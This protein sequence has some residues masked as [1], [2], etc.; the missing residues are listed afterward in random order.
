MHLATVQSGIALS[1]ELIASSDSIF[2]EGETLEWGGVR[3]RGVPSVVCGFLCHGISSGFRGICGC[4]GFTL[5]PWPGMC[6]GWGKARVKNANL[7]DTFADPLR[8]CEVSTSCQATTSCKSVLRV[9]PY[10]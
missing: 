8:N 1:R 5:V 3:V 9:E 4:L 10:H 7:R 6:G 2:V